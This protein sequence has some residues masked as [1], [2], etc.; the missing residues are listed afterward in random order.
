M[1]RLLTPDG[2]VLP[3]SE[4][5]LIYFASYLARTARHSTIKLY[6]AAVRNLHITAGY[7][8]PLKGKL[9]LRKVLRGILRYQGNQRIR[10]LPVTPQILLAIRPVLH[11]WLRPR[12]FSMIWAAFNLA[13]FAFLRCSEFTY[14]GV[15]KFRPSLDLSTDCITFH[16]NLAHPQ[17]MTVYLKSSKTDISREGHSL[18]IARTLSPL[19]A[20]V[21]MQEYFL[22]ARPQPGPLFYFQSGRYLTRSVVSNLLRDS[23]RVAGFP[24]R[25]LKGHSFRIGAASVAAAAGLPDWLIKVLGRWSSDCY[26]LYIRTPQSTLESV[27]PRMAAVSG[28]F[29]PV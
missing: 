1:N 28:R 11:A 2:D 6:L 18:T 27:A 24:Y 20:V 14:S 9:L 16:P 7:N 4:G 22:L 8:D 10:R 12:D 15:Y 21:A 19:C 23:T 17:R 13:F 26:Q 3:A 25:S 5:T 29:S